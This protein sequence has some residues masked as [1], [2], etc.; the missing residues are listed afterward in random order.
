MIATVLALAK[1]AGLRLLTAGWALWLSPAGKALIKAGLVAA[2]IGAAWWWW[3]DTKGDLIEQGRREAE[4]AIRQEIA[5]ANSEAEREADERANKAER[6]AAEVPAVPERGGDLDR[7]CR[8]D[9]ACRD[10][11]GG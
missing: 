5:A 3:A 10:R 2:L 9:P 11:A 1:I 8:E 6:A 7:L 4:A